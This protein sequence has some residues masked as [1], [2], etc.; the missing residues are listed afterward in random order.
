[1]H[2]LSSRR[3]GPELRV[4]Q[5]AAL[6]ID[7]ERNYEIRVNDYCQVR[8]WSARRA[9]RETLRA[10]VP[11]ARAL[12]WAR[13]LSAAF[14]LAC[15]VERPALRS[16]SARD[17]GWTPRRRA[18]STSREYAAPDIRRSRALVAMSTSVG[19]GRRIADSR[20]SCDRQ[21][22][23]RGKPQVRLRLVFRGAGDGQGAGH[24]GTGNFRR[25]TPVSSERRSS[26]IPST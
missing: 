26:R 12:T 22:S 19:A 1:M 7:S 21:E 20:A 6:A 24:A 13:V 25:I 10:S 18:S 17:S 16:S 11:D 5:W 15:D 3:P 4:H 23:S 14:V 9:S 8:R 2:G